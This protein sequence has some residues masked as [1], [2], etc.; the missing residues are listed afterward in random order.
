[1]FYG[2]F[3]GQ[4]CES[5]ILKKLIGVLE[6]QVRKRRKL[7]PS[8]WKQFEEPLKRPFLFLRQENVSNADLTNNAGA[9]SFEK[10][11]AA[12]RSGRSAF[13]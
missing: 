13:F 3:S 2:P 7:A 11:F 6:D 12:F 8:E 5:N 1:M 4:V 9:Q 10:S